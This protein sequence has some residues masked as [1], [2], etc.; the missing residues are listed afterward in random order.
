MLH[1]HLF[2]PLYKFSQTIEINYYDFQHEC[3]PKMHFLN[4]QMM[5]KTSLVSYLE[6]KIRDSVSCLVATHC[7]YPTLVRSRNGASCFARLESQL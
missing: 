5:R 6:A 1:R 3:T 7:Q 2:S 4:C